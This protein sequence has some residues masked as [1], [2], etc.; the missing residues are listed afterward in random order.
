MNMQSAHNL[1]NLQ[2]NE[3]RNHIRTNSPVELY[4]KRKRGKS[5]FNHV[6]VIR[7]EDILKS[8]CSTIVVTTNTVGVM[9]AGLAKSARNRFPKILKPYQSACKSGAHTTELPFLIGN[10][11]CFA[12]KRHWQDSSRTEWIESGLQ[13]IVANQDLLGDSIAIPALGAGLGRLD[14]T[15]QVRPLLIKYLP[16]LRIKVKL[17]LNI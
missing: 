3:L 8:E 1:A 15:Q 6:E 12:T 17:Y 14:F 7:G 11:L 13:W 2:A 9:G 16:Q 4:P 5:M 10:I